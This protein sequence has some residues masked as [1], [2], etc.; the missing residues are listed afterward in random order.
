MGYTAIF[1]GTFNPFHIGHYEMLSAL[2]DSPLV[3]EILVIP[4]KTPPHKECVFSVSDKD[5]IK[6]CELVAAD[7]PK[8]NVCLLEFEREGKSYTVDTVLRLKQEFPNKNFG[9]VCGADLLE[10]LDCWYDFP[11]LKQMVTFLAFRRKGI[12]DF[13]FQINRLKNLQVK[14]QVFDTEIQAVSST[15]FRNSLKKEFLP[16]VVFNYIKSRGLYLE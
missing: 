11:R 3:D 10:K 12:Q 6:M 8:A 15:E 4:A 2:N 1:G 13:D 7:F 16:S 14:F 5:R 9:V